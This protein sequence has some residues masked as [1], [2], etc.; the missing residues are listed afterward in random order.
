MFLGTASVNNGSFNFTLDIPNAQIGTHQIKATDFY[1]QMVLVA[2]FEVI[3]GGTVTGNGL[4]ITLSAGTL[5]FPGDAA[6]ANILTSVVGGSNLPNLQ[7][8]RVTLYSP[9]NTTVQLTPR[10]LGPGLY[11][12]SYPISTT[13]RL[14]TYTIRALAMSAQNGNASAIVS[15]EVKPTWLQ[16]HATQVAAGGAATAGIAGTAIAVWY[17]KRRPDE[18]TPF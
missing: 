15:F 6:V 14:G 1:A 3:S 8:L 9:D 5:Y 13:A 11:V 7:S 17:R 10:N 12:V 2:N 16:T 18:S 4:S